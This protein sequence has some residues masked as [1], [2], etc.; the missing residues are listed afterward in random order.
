MSKTR[1]VPD[2]KFAGFWMLLDV[3]CQIP[4]P[5]FG[6]IK[7]LRGSIFSMNNFKHLNNE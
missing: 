5:E 2:V 3:I 6:K 4:D 7:R 1:D